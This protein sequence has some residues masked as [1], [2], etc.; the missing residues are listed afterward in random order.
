MLEFF[1]RD[2]RFLTTAGGRTP[3]TAGDGELANILDALASILAAPV[4]GN[5]KI[6]AATCL[7]ATFDAV[8]AL[9]GDCGAEATWRAFGNAA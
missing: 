6:S 7:T 4:P 1:A 9:E 5:L 8:V 2:V 3:G